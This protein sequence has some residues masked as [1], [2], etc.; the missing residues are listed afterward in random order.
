MSVPYKP[1]ELIQLS[2]AWDHGNPTA[3]AA[4]DPSADELRDLGP[5]NSGY[6]ARFC[7]ILNETIDWPIPNG[8][9]VMF[10]DCVTHDRGWTTDHWFKIFHDNGIYWV[11]ESDVVGFRS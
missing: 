3:W 7:N 9:W 4:Q 11:F 2:A 1:G 10:L 5:R 8:T 6:N